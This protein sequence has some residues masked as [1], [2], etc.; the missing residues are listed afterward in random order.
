MT[1]NKKSLR[2][3]QRLCENEGKQKERNGKKEKN[4]YEVSQS[5]IKADKKPNQKVIPCDEFSQ[6]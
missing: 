3:V 5:F 4:F 2:N 1:E 6:H